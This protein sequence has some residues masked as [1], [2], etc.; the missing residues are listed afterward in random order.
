MDIKLLINNKAKNIIKSILT[1]SLKNSSNYELILRWLNENRNVKC[2][3]LYED[4]IIKSFV[5]LSKCD[6]DPFNK[7]S[8]PY[9][10]D[11]IYTFEQFRRNNYAFQLL[12][13]LKNNNDITAFCSN[14]FSVNL[15][16][17]VGYILT[18]YPNCDIDTF[19]FP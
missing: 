4:G 5:L 8:N 2:Y 18:N 13:Y 12:N 6:F 17:K 15:F 11:L 10:L 3:I 19:R 16:H 9:I 7:H 1:P 14:Y